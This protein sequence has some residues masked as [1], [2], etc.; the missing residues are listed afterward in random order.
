MKENNNF[1]RR[2]GV[3][4][5]GSDRSFWDGFLDTPNEQT[6]IE[7]ARR[8]QHK[9]ESLY[10][11]SNVGKTLD[12]SNLHPEQRPI[13]RDG[14]TFEQTK[15]I[16]NP[17]KKPEYWYQGDPTQHRVEGP[18]GVQDTHWIDPPGEGRKLV[19]YQSYKPYHDPGDPNI[20]G[21]E[22]ISEFIAA[23]IA[24]QI[25]LPVNKVRLGR[26]P[27]GD[28]VSV[29]EEIPNAKTMEDPA[30][31]YLNHK[32]P[33]RAPFHVFDWFIGNQDRHAGNMMVD[34]HDKLW[35]I[36]HSWHTV[37]GSTPSSAYHPDHI[38]QHVIR[39]HL[40]N[41]PQYDANFKETLHKLA[42]LPDEYFDHLG[43]LL[44]RKGAAYA[45]DDERGGQHVRGPEQIVAMLKTQRNRAANE[46][47]S[48][49]QRN[50]F[51]NVD[52]NKTLDRSNLHPE[53]R[54]VERDGKTF[55][56]T[57]WVDNLKQ[58]DHWFDGDPTQNRTDGPKGIQRT[59]WIDH[60]TGKKLVKYTADDSFFGNEPVHEFIT[61]HLANRVGIAANRV[62]FG[63]TPEGD[64]VSVH[65]E[66]PNAETLSWH[67]RENGVN[68]HPEAQDRGFYGH[69][70]LASFQAFDWLVGNKD[71]HDGN[72]MIDQDNKRWAIDHGM[73]DVGR[74]ETRYGSL[75]KNWKEH[76]DMSSLPSA[77][78]FPEHHHQLKQTLRSIVN[79]KD[80]YFDHLK[81]LLPT[82][83]QYPE[84]V[85]PDVLVG[86][87]K[88]RRDHLRSKYKEWYGEEP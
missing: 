4:E 27:G 31:G 41:D 33:R 88:Q 53:Q 6:V 84:G 30:L 80:D 73:L 63:E 65:D 81:G 74:S 52:I 22:P 61:S 16:S 85:N 83:A 2:E 46:L 50:K 71:R 37:G 19:K 18:G 7:R 1:K 32:D 54:T 23:H 75:Y 21:S 17:E 36:D 49:Q 38:F 28:L 26:T 62:R 11:H 14:K 67:R 69:P 72:M 78:E 48:L 59:H 13:K 51:T 68:D 24:N 56:Q 43:S 86:R 66:I 60:P 34:N 76:P 79:I 15:W 42:D 9:W 29:H 35:G 20:V 64:M 44:P 40:S 55:E 58:H 25:G 57:K 8:L 10:L 12:R 87:L 39:S 45:H 82:H 3:D 47:L 77:T 70:D 5:N